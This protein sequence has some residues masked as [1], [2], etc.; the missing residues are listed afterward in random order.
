MPREIIYVPQ[1][2]VPVFGFRTPEKPVEV[3]DF[4]ITATIIN[5][6][7][8]VG[9]PLLVAGWIMTFF[10]TLIIIAAVLDIVIFLIAKNLL[11][12]LWSVITDSAT[13]IMGRFARVIGIVAAIFVVYVFIASG[14]WKEAERFLVEWWNNSADIIRE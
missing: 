8:A 10:M 1:E 13:G 4:Y 9:N 7:Q 14:A 6:L 2:K 3:K 11:V 5:N 12:F